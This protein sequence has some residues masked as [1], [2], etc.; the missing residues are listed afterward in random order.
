M[1]IPRLFAMLVGKEY[2]EG[3]LEELETHHATTK[4]RIHAE[5]LGKVCLKYPNE[6][7]LKLSAIIELVEKEILIPLDERYREQR[8]DLRRAID[9]CG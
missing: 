4:A 7:P 5:V 3:K 6:D 9:V 8:R 1:R 2:L